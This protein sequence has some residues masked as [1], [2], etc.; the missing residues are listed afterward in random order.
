LTQHLDGNNNSAFGYF[1]LVNLT[2]GSRNL[3]LGQNA[4]QNLASGSDN[5]YIDSLGVGGDAG[6]IRIGN[7]N[8]VAAFIEGIFG[9]TSAGG[10]AVF[11]NA[12]N[13]LGTLTSSRRYKERI[14]DMG[15]ESDVLRRLRPVS[16]RYRKEHDDSG[17]RQYGLIAEEVA[18]VAPDLV[19]FDEQGAPQ[20]VR[21]HFVN[22]MLL[23]EVQKQRT[24]ID[25][26]RT[27]I[28]DQRSRIEELEGR[29]L[30]LESALAGLAGSR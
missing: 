30:R 7:A 17:L 13:Q 23:N 6:R 3:A 27:E 28:Q 14:A 12:S 11:I 8:H 2:T 5:I 16:F 19:V 25:G 22:A 1:A 24:L 15:A 10:T 26:Q 29:L 18:E 21:Y 4:G 9:A 20:T